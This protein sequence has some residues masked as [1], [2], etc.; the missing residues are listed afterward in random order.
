MGWVHQLVGLINEE[1]TSSHEHLLSALL[2]LVR[3]HIPSLEDCRDPKL[4][5]QQM[6]LAYIEN[7]KGKE[8]CQV[9]YS[10]VKLELS[11]NRKNV[12]DVWCLIT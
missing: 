5:L 9:Y 1:R 11:L 12:D 7:V 6:L 2:A 3:D 10:N 4:Q 8:E